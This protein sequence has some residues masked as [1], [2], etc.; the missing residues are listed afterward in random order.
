MRKH[1]KGKGDFIDQHPYLVL[2]SLL[3]GGGYLAWYFLKPKAAATPATIPSGTGEALPGGGV[4][5]STPAY[6]LDP[7]GDCFK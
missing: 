1:K 7:G 3:A 5:G 6:C 2:G 4:T